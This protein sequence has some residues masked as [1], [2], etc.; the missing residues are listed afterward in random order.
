MSSEAVPAMAAS[1]RRRAP[2]AW[3]SAAVLGRRRRRDAAERRF[4]LAGFLAFLIAAGFL[5]FLLVTI[6]AAGWNSFRSAEVRVPVVLDPAVLGVAPDAR[7]PAVLA[8]ADYQAAVA[9]SAARAGL[10]PF[11][12]SDGAWLVVRDRLVA[13]PALLGQT[14]PLW[15][16]ARSH[17]DLLAKGEIDT[18]AEEGDRP[19]SDAEIAA[20]RA[21][22]DAGELRLAF[23]RHFL[24]GT[25]SVDPELAGIWGALKGS[26][27]TI[28]VTLALA[29]PVGVFSAVYLEEFAPRSRWTELVEVSIN[30][31]AAVPSIIFGLLGLAL[32][33]NTLNMPRSAPV[34][35]GLTLALMT[36]PII[37]VAARAALKAVPPSIRDAALGVGA[38]KVQMV[39]HHVLPLALPGILTGTIIGAARAL[40][41]TAP[42]LLIGMRAFIT[43]VPQGVRDPATVL[44]VQIF[45]WS[46]SVARG[47]IEKTS[48]AIIVLLL[49]LLLMNSVA[50]YLRYR[51][52]VRW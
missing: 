32:F 20:Y 34:V 37:V 30:N 3:A 40:G 5:A 6:V 19:V 15:L 46:D 18:G 11:V 29:F 27:L 24:F 52:E 14:V 48:G 25:D 36:L 28:L 1:A 39:F 7:D 38:S 9:D 21:L 47:F 41:E 44:P 22:R 4:R 35:G 10:P 42:L 49:F 17:I 2:T 26:L 50:T 13:N 12:V 23:N 16:T 8:G 43:S 51:T 31:L 45:I 33:L